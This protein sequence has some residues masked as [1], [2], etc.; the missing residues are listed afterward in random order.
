MARRRGSR[1]KVK[2]KSRLLRNTAIGLGAL[3][4][5][6]GLGYGAYRLWKGRANPA[7]VANAAN[8]VG[9][10]SSGKRQVMSE[11]EIDT[12]IRSGGSDEDL[13]RK[14]SDGVLRGNLPQGLN[15]GK[16]GT[17]TGKSWKEANR[18]KER[19]NEDFIRKYQGN[20]QRDI[21]VNA[22]INR[23]IGAFGMYYNTAEFARRRGSRDKKK[24]RSRGLGTAAAIGGTGLAGVGAIRYGG[25]ALNNAAIGENGS[26]GLVGDV[27]SKKLV[28]GTGARAA[29]VAALNDLQRVKS[30]LGRGYQSLENN[31]GR[32]YRGAKNT[33][34]TTGK[35]LGGHWNNIGL[36]T[37]PA[38]GSI[39]KAG[40]WFKE[41]FAAGGG[42]GA[43]AGRIAAGAG[44]AGAALGGGYLGYRA[45][46][47]RKK[48]R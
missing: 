47:K 23:G 20:L 34:A 11:K 16:P 3:G 5:T 46:T 32:L 27:K 33:L 19:Q 6:A 1:D 39:G 40:R 31:V 44:I 18:I 12:L 8:N 9:K 24:R 42:M 7:N 26:V 43:R 13:L 22:L 14:G 10:K 45:L 4:A 30:G 21:E 25:A 35:N 28:A 48:R 2:R 41:P 37:E 38:R 29:R 36:A 15:K 17:K